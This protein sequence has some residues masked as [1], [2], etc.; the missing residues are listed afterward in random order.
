MPQIVCATPEILNPTTCNDRGGFYAA[1]WT[2]YEAVDWA[3]MAADNSKFDQTTATL[4]DYTMQTGGV[5]NILTSK[6]KDAYYEATF[7]SENDYWELLVAQIFEGKDVA[8]TNAFN[9]AIQCCQ[10]ILHLFANNG[11]DRVFGVDWNGTSFQ[12]TLEPLR[13][14]RVLDAGGQI[15]SNKARDEMDLTGQSLFAPIH[16]TMAYAN[17][18]LT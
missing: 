5:F 18:P 6:A 7:T 1:G 12:P 17:L 16:S 8:R 14:G 4:L 11:K 10:L 15:G 13:V 9:Q 2:T 3:A